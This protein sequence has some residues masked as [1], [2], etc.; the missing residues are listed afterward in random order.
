MAGA[1]C[2]ILM[3]EG[4]AK[5]RHDSVSGDLVYRP[6]VPMNPL[7]HQL[8]DS[9]EKNARFL[10]VT[11]GDKLHRAFNIGKQNCDLL[12]LTFKRTARGPDFL[13]EVFRSVGP[14]GVGARRGNGECRSAPAA[15]SPPWDGFGATGGTTQR[16]RTAAIFT[17]P[18]P[19][20][21]LGMAPR[22]PHDHPANVDNGKEDRKRVGA[23][24]G[25][26]NAV[27]SN[28]ST[29]SRGDNMPRVGGS[30]S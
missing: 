6:L 7:H 20:P 30:G 3:G 24:R 14:R 17:E 8:Y 1:G 11:I 21:V 28:R 22:T 19:L 15:E 5:E 27:S 4:C 26:V 9:V 23:S 29:N 13:G 25:A 2:V 18:H 12:A 10:W 16:Q